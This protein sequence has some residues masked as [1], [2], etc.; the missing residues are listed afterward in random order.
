M[1][2]LSYNTEFLM[3][4]ARTLGTIRTYVPGG[5]AV[6]PESIILH[7]TA[8][9]TTAMGGAY[10]VARLVPA[11]RATWEAQL[12]AYVPPADPHIISFLGGVM[13]F[14]AR[15]YT[16]DSGPIVNNGDLFHSQVV[17]L[18]EI[19]DLLST[20]SYILAAVP[21]YGEPKL[22]TEAS[23]LGL[24]YYINRDSNGEFI[25]QYAEDP[26]LASI[27][28]AAGGYSKLQ[29]LM[30]NG[31]ATP[32]QKQ[33]L[34]KMANSRVM[35]DM[36]I[37]GVRY[38]LQKVADAPFCCNGGVNYSLDTIRILTQGSID[39]PGSPFTTTLATGASAFGLTANF[40]GLIDGVYPIATFFAGAPASP[41]TTLIPGEPVPAVINAN[42]SYLRGVGPDF[43]PAGVAIGA[44]S[45]GPGSEL[46]YLK[47]I[48][49]YE[50][51]RDAELR[52]N[53]RTLVEPKSYEEIETFLAFLMA[54]PGDNVCD[55]CSGLGWETVA[56]VTA[57][58]FDLT[59]SCYAPQS[60]QGIHPIDLGFITANNIISNGPDIG[61]LGR[62]NPVYSQGSNI[63]I[64][65]PGA[66]ASALHMHANPVPIVRF[67][68]EVDPAAVAPATHVTIIPES[69]TRSYRILP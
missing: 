16:M 6:A 4:H 56:F 7:D 67:D 1:P 49:F 54:Q 41:N 28:A 62:V 18:E 40:G 11:N 58:Y 5:V 21:D 20:G 34:Y 57:T 10:D 31:T 38:I 59:D 22:P 61:W 26:V 30:L 63:P 53:G 12:A 25:L 45:N 42:I 3:R 23:N 68:I 46:G 51:Q 65:A 2:S 17:D 47:G 33:A 15:E 48:T 37:K 13:E 52:I 36:C 60:E 69:V 27:V 66:G 64:Y 55:P 8:T 9:L 35:I 44:A 14:G 19:W 32:L 43:G 39:L 24:D 29:S 50:S